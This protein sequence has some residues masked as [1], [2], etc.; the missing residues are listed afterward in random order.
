MVNNN[1][2]HVKGMPKYYKEC[3]QCGTVSPDL[4]M[5]AVSGKLK[6]PSQDLRWER[7]WLIHLFGMSQL[8]VCTLKVIVEQQLFS[9]YQALFKEAAGVGQGYFLSWN[10]PSCQ[11]PLIIWRFHGFMTQ[12]VSTFPLPQCSS[13]YFSEENCLLSGGRRDLGNRVWALAICVWDLTL[14]PGCWEL[15]KLK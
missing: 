7:N 10:P 6:V 11:E 1:Q 2:S 4:F 3:F 12:N 9:V 5:L 14:F 8:N 13:Y 15:W